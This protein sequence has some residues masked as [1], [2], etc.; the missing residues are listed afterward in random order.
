MPLREFVCA[1]V[2]TSRNVGIRMAGSIL[3]LRCA[4]VKEVDRGEL[5]YAVAIRGD[6]RGKMMVHIRD[7]I[8]QRVGGVSRSSRYSTAC[9]TGYGL[10]V[11]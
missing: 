8:R 5:R 7:E 9:R 6:A 4:Q 3:T 2:A 1:A 10:N 11:R